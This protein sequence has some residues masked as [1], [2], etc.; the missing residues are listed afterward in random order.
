MLQGKN[1]IMPM[2][3][4]YLMVD[5]SASKTPSKKPEKDAIWWAVRSAAGREAD[6][7]RRLKEI[8]KSDESVKSYYSGTQV[9]EATRAAAINHIREFVSQEADETRRVLVGFDFAFGYPCGFAGRIIEP[10]EVPAV[11]L[12][13]DLDRRVN[14]EPQ[15]KCDR[16]QVAKTW[17]DIF[18]G[19]GS[20]HEGPF[21]SVSRAEAL[22]RKS[23]G[24]PHKKSKNGRETWPFCFGQRRVTDTLA[25]GAQ[26]VW[27]LDGPGAVG[28]QVLL[29][30]P[31]LHRLRSSLRATPDS[32]DRCVVWPFDTGFEL[33]T[34]SEQT[35]IVIVEI[36]PSLLRDAI[37]KGQK[38]DEVRDCAQVRLNALAF[39]RLDERGK[40]G[41]L[42]LGPRASEPKMC[43][44][45]VKS[46][47]REEGWI[48]GVDGHQFQ[49][50]CALKDCDQKET[51]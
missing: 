48:F 29:G 16:Y 22:G 46:I 18:K 42:F 5:W 34:A 21:W 36:F 45:W 20:G 2:F 44:E 14:D 17:N 11:Q 10:G 6:V 7:L 15:E 49:L 19:S 3:D 25:S 26:T 1:K 41:P 31:W 24:N 51:A 50:L 8:R 39:S 12:W 37:E 47:E 35:R 9:H 38:C 28:S 32:Q 40:L 4:T 30:L 23:A 33:P 27:Q 13:E 43:Q